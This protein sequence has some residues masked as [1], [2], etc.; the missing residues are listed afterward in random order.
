MDAN[1][2]K[3]ILY[4]YS[5]GCLDK[6]DYPQLAKYINSGSGMFA[7]ELSDLQ[8]IIALIPAVLDIEQPSAKLKDKVARKLYR[9]REETRVEKKPLTAAA[10]KIDKPEDDTHE[11]DEKVNSSHSPDNLNTSGKPIKDTEK[12]ETKH[13]NPVYMP[14]SEPV[15]LE[16]PPLNNIHFTDLQHDGTPGDKTQDITVEGNTDSVIEGKQF[17]PQAELNQYEIAHPQELDINEKE[18]Y[19]ARSQK[20]FKYFMLSVVV[21]MALCS[22]MYYF[23]SKDINKQKEQINLLS[24]QVSTLNDEVA[25]LQKNQRVIA[26][27]GERDTKTYN[28]D[29]TEVNPKGIGKLTFSPD[30]SEGVIQ[31]YNMPHL[32][33]NQ[34]YQ[35]WVTGGSQP[36]SMGAFK[37][38][39]DVEYF[40]LDQLPLDQGQI[41]SFIVTLEENGGAAS[42]SKN[43]Y[44]SG[45]INKTPTG[46]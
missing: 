10:S 46:L 1:K 37:M 18:L 8:N 24:G 20:G 44:L 26:I 41:V 45:L 2:L 22:G 7:K 21:S 39:R 31:L 36:I 29:A 5:A 23:M 6:E 33:G 14:L 9:M 34:V 11:S 38:R 42:P 30:G 32:N 35:L 40:S 16:N 15:H 12:E 3:E 27:L 19:S 17:V 28:L 25:K 4:A 13:M 43:V